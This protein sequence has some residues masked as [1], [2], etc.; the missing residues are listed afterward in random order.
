MFEFKRLKVLCL[1]NVES[2]FCPSVGGGGVGEVGGEVLRG[3]GASLSQLTLE[4]PM[5]K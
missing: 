4:R 2:M 1:N 5:F 3:W